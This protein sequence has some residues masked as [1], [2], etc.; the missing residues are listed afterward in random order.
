[1]GRAAFTKAYRHPEFPG[2]Q[3]GMRVLLHQ[4]ANSGHFSLSGSTLFFGFF[5]TGFFHL[6]Y[7]SRFT[8]VEDIPILLLLQN[9]LAAVSTGWA[10]GCLFS[11]PFSASLPWLQ[12]ADQSL[13]WPYWTLGGRTDLSRDCRRSLSG[14]PLLPG[15]IGSYKS[16]STWLIAYTVHIN[17]R[18]MRSLVPLLI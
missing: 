5:V 14:C 6:A 9:T 11:H 1:M 12:P 10:M 17:G 4:F 15:W 8:H 2:N 13:L 16:T 3:V 7:A 18:Y